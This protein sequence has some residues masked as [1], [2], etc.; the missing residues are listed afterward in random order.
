MN[1]EQAHASLSAINYYLR[2][3]E[4]SQV[5]NGEFW[6]RRAS[7][8]MNRLQRQIKIDAMLD[9]LFPDIADTCITYKQNKQGRPDDMIL[10]DKNKLLSLLAA[11]GI[12][13]R[14][15]MARA[16]DVSANTMVRLLQ[17]KRTHA[18]TARRLAGVAGAEV[19]E[20]FSDAD[21]ESVEME[22]SETSNDDFD[23]GV[24]NGSHQ[25][26]NFGI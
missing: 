21:V 5:S 6:R 12:F 16:I 18:S 25:K 9:E 7:A 24:T 14:I 10:K 1:K 20:L 3:A 23:I 13:K 4:T 11:K 17:G 26:Q 19:D 22:D 2:N 15:D 8:E